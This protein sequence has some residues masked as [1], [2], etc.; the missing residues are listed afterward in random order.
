MTADHTIYRCTSCGQLNRHP[1]DSKK[2]GTFKCGK[3]GTDFLLVMPRPTKPSALRQLR[4][5]FLF[6]V[7]SGVAVN[8][9]YVASET[10]PQSRPAATTNVPNPSSTSVGSS[11]KT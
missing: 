6:L 3:C 4:K 8:F 5:V 11:Q 10:L 2:A 1:T 9:I 7:L